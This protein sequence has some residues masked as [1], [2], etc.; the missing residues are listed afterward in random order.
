MGGLKT[1]FYFIAKYII[2]MIVVMLVLLANEFI[3]RYAFGING[4][5][6]NEQ[7]Y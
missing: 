3:L 1:N 7:N 2:A 4:Y 5:Y 6:T